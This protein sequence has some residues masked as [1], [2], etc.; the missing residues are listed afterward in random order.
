MYL[1]QILRRF[2]LNLNFTIY[3]SYYTLKSLYF[4]HIL[5]KIK[6]TVP[7]FIFYLT[8]TVSPSYFTKKWPVSSS[9]LYFFFDIVALNTNTLFVSFIPE[10]GGKVLFSHCPHSL[11]PA[12]FEGLHL[13][14]QEEVRLGQIQWKGCQIIWIPLAAI[15]SCTCTITCGEQ[16]ECRDLCIVPIEIPLPAIGYR[17]SLQLE[18]LHVPAQGLHDKEG[19]DSG[20][21]VCV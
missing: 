6:L 21:K 13:R 11:L 10:V 9:S 16:P 5:P 15:Q 14:E 8:N 1:S 3:S 18:Y 4:L 19:V 20:H 2:K 12:P 7:F 17:T